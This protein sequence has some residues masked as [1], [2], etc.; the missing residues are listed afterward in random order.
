[1]LVDEV[2]LERRQH[3]AKIKAKKSVPHTLTGIAK[4]S[5]LS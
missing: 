1:M 4:T 3:L 5:R 2:R